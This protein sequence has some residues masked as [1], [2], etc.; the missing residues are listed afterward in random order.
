MLPNVEFQPLARWQQNRWR[1]QQAHSGLYMQQPICTVC[2]NSSTP[3]GQNILNIRICL[4]DDE[5][6]KYPGTTSLSALG[7]VLHDSDRNGCRRGL[8]P[9]TVIA[10]NQSNTHDAVLQFWDIKNFLPAPQLIPSDSWRT[11]IAY[12]L[13]YT[14]VK[15]PSR[16]TSILQLSDDIDMMSGA[17]VYEEIGLPYRLCAL[18]CNICRK[19]S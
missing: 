19:Q 8:R 16:V 6:S 11:G 1:L 17:P 18:C 2:T 9:I 3:Y 4:M 5:W 14:R 7:Y 13:P 10:S 12:S 15:R